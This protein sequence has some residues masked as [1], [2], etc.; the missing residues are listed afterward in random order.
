MARDIQPLPLLRGDL[1]FEF[2]RRTNIGPV[3]T[4]SL[5][6]ATYDNLPARVATRGI[7]AFNGAA[8]P[9]TYQ[10]PSL[11]DFFTVELVA[12]GGRG[13]RFFS[14]PSNP[15]AG[16]GSIAWTADVVGP[17]GAIRAT[18]DR[19]SE[20]RFLGFNT[21]QND[22]ELF[23]DCAVYGTQVHVPHQG[24]HVEYFAVAAPGATTRIFTPPQGSAGFGAVFTLDTTSAGPVTLTIGQN[25]LTGGPALTIPAIAPGTQLTLGPIPPSETFEITSDVGGAFSGRFAVQVPLP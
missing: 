15:G 10:G 6:S 18:L 13:G 8:A 2:G 16:W 9:G 1:P 21:F 3:N 24:V 19:S 12:R 22:P 5:R 23:V 11:P 7:V 25:P 20:I 14:A 17:Y 4:T